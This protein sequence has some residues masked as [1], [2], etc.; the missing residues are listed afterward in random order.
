MTTAPKPNWYLREWMAHLNKRQ[1]DL[2]RDRGWLKG[3]ASKIVGGAHQYRRDLIN[4]LSDWLG[5]EPFELLMPPYE[6][7]K[8]R[9]WKELI[10]AEAQNMGHPDAEKDRAASR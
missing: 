9:R 5:I 6:A 10:A 4:E 1:A 8:Y 7:M 3:R 2:V